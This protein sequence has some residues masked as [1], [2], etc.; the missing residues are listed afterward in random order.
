M[1]AQ[2][3][4][5]NGRSARRLCDRAPGDQL[6]AG[7]ALAQD[8]HVDVLRGDAADRLAHLLHDGAAADDAVGALLGRQQRGH[9]HQAGGLEGAVEDLAEPVEVDRLDEVVEGALLHRLDGGLG[10]AVG[11]DEDDRAASGRQRLDVVEDVQA[12]AVGQLQVEHD[13]VG[14]LR[15]TSV[16]PSAAVAAV[17]TF[18]SSP[19][20]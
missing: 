17:R 2:L 14:R 9:A 6:L 1:A 7:A 12:G 4:A 20:T 19:K 3:M 15:A 8:Q 18:A 10:G 5:R 11:G 13:D 16:E